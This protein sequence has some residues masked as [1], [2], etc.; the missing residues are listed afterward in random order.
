M[1]QSI[2]SSTTTGTTNHN[3]V[4]GNSS[5]ILGKDDFLKML[6][7]QLKYQD[8]LNPL[9]GTE[10]AAQLAQFSS[11][12]QL[13]NI[14]TNLSQFM[15][16]NVALASS[17]NNALAPTFIG[18]TVR[19]S[20]NAFTYTGTGS[21]ELGYTISAPVEQVLIKV[22]DSNGTIV[23]VLK[24]STKNGENTIEWNGKTDSGEQAPSGR[25]TVTIEA[26]G[27]D[28]QRIDVPAFIYGKITGVRFKS[29]G[30]VF[31]LNGVEVLLGDIVEIKEE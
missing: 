23:K 9:N 14:K 3:S 20:T 11:V 24:G 17:I 13:T 1:T 5:A 30:T 28:G 12:E 4:V 18:K 2:Q 6:I 22:Y 25:Y 19:A 26:I 16:T 15:N 8:P 31:V 21:V 10:F 27:S 7:M 29:D